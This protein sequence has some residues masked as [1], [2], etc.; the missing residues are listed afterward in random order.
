[1]FLELRTQK[2]DTTLR[3]SSVSAKAKASTVMFISKLTTKVCT[4]VC[5]DMDST[6]TLVDECLLVKI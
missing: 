4:S 1:M 2:N 3:I 5:A 6:V